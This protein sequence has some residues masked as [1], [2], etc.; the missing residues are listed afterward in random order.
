MKFIITLNIKT[1]N[2]TKKFYFY[3]N[4]ILEVIQKGYEEVIKFGK[5]FYE[6]DNFR[7]NDRSW[8]NDLSFTYEKVI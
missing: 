8:I 5:E 1:W 7:T 3:S 4:S 6:V 2:K